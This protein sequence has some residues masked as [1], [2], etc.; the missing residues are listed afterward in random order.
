MT[1]R[2]IFMAR[3]WM[4]ARYL[5][6]SDDWPDGSLRVLTQRRAGL[7]RALV[8]GEV[9]D[10][11]LI[12]PHWN[13]ITRDTA[14]D[15]VRFHDLTGSPVVGA[16]LRARGF[17]QLDAR[18]R[19]L[20]IATLVIDLSS[21]EDELLARMTANT[22]RN[23]KRA[24]AAGVTIRGDAH[25]DPALVERFI[26]TFNAMAAERKLQPVTATTVRA[27]I[28]GRHSR[29]F[30]SLHEGEP[31]SFLLSYEAAG[32]ALLATSA[33]AAR[34]HNGG[35]HLLHWEALRAFRASGL[36][37][38]D[39]AGITSTDPDDGIFQFKRGFGGEIVDLG[40]EFGRTGVAVRAARVLRDRWQG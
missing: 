19:M 35:G 21:S 5:G 22:R 24:Q 13:R 3:D 33:A 10:P 32:T 39:M 8:V 2:S 34:E 7:R 40:Q 37:W 1:Y 17:S 29:L 36:R 27:M 14:F 26:A 38:C 15:E 23:I 16:W 11:G 31:C 28:A 12:A 18:Q 20:N 30:A 9:D 6:W 4:H 25:G